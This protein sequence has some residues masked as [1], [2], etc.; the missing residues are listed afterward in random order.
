MFKL[1]PITTVKV[2]SVKTDADHVKSLAESIEQIDLLNPITVNEDM[3]LI[4][5]AHRY[6]AARLAG[7]TKIAVNIVDLDE[8]GQQLAKLDENLRQRPRTQLELAEMI[9]ERKRLLEGDEEKPVTKRG[10]A[11][12]KGEKQTADSAVRATAQLSQKSERQVREYV[13]V[14]E[15]LDPKAKKTIAKTAAADNLSDLQR[16]AKMEPEQQREVAARVAETGA[17]VKQ[18]ARELKLE[19]QVKQARV[20]VPPEGEYEVV[21]VDPPWPYDDTLDGSDAARGGLPYP[22]M[23]IFSIAALDLKLAKDAAVFL[24]V[25]N[26]HL[27]DPGAYG[28]VVES[29]RALYGLE[30]KGIATWEKDRIGLGRYFRNKTEHLVLLVRG[31][32]VFTDEKPWSHFKAPVGEHSEKPAAAY[33]AIEKFCASTSR[34]EMFARAERAGWVTSGSEL[35]AA[36]AAT[37]PK[38]RKRT[39]DC[40]GSA[41]CAH[42]NPKDRAA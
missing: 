31:K 34:L 18:A 23:S 28:V 5:G 30:P 12:K 7:H 36:P 24:W 33:M 37:P 17:S 20:H 39:V 27:I 35:E 1:V 16:L 2:G 4:A 9:A 11:R 25:T 42:C 26:S 41:N 10:G 14:A 13:A 29:W 6:R 40:T 22:P 15:K 21:V 8:R 38:Q 32:P 3:E 19:Q